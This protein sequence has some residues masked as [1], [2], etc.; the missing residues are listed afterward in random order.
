MHTRQCKEMVYENRSSRATHLQDTRKV[1]AVQ[2]EQKRVD[3][4]KAGEET[5]QKEISS[6][7]KVYGETRRSS[8]E[9]KR[10]LNIEIASEIADLILDVAEETYQVA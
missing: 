9:V 8:K 7:R 2:L 6:N 3:E 1:I 4:A 5:R 10:G